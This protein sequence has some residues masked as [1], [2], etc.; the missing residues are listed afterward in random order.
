MLV[1]TQWEPLVPNVTINLYQEGFAADGV[2]PTL[3]L[4]DTTKTS[5]FDDWAQGFRADNGFPNMN[6]PGQG[7]NTGPLADLFYYSLFN[8]PSYLDIEFEHG[9]PVALDG[10]RLDG[11]TLIARLNDLAG[12]HGVGRI[13]HVE[14]RFVGIKSRE[15]YECPA[16]VV[17]HQAHAVLETLIKAAEGDGRD[18]R[19]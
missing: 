5:S 13:D 8:Q 10:E 7:M 4:V 1:Q 17:L 14:N 6:C 15:I 3:R 9:V 19:K 2:T 11:P 18:S 16:G 12:S